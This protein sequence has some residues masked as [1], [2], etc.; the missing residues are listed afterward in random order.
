MQLALRSLLLF[1]AFSP[2]LRAQPVADVLTRQI[3]W[4]P[5][6][7]SSGNPDLP[8]NGDSRSIEAGAELVLGELEGPGIINH[9]WSTIST[10]DVF[11][12]RSLVL[13]IYYDGATRPSVQV[14]FGDFFGVGHGAAAD[15]QSAITAISSY[16]RARS[17]YWKMPFY[18]HAKVV[19]ANDGEHRINSFYY[20]LDW[21][22]HD[23][24]P[25][26]TVY[27][28]ARYGQEQATGPEDFVLLN[29]TGRGH[30]VGT[31]WSCQMAEKGWFGEGDDRFYI[32]GE[33]FPSLR[34]T[35]TEDYFGDAWG[36]RQF[37]TPYFG[38]SLWEGYMPGDRGTAYRW[39]LTDPIPF[40]ESLKVHMETRGSIYGNGMTFH[41]QF[42]PRQDF[43]SGG[44]FWYQWPKV[45]IQEDLP[46]A[47]ERIAPYQFLEMEDLEITAEPRIGM[48]KSKEAF[49]YLCRSPKAVV[50]IE[51]KV[52][53]DGT[54][55]INPIMN[56]GG[57]GGVYQPSINGED[58]GGPIDFSE[59]GGF[60]WIWTRLDLHE[61]EAQ[62][63]HTLTFTGQG[64]S[65]H[66]RTDMG[67]VFGLGLA[68]IAVL[69]VED[70]PGYHKTLEA[71]K[72]GTIKE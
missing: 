39:H 55:Q 15:Y 22:K 40:K 56:Y 50:K 54:Y 35:G 23:S 49:N 47:G 61:L 59:K 6:R 30:Y 70:L 68:R 19:V 38:V 37:A 53:E 64:K 46:S 44:A 67:D 45:E 52:P 2:S 26:D 10:D 69:R 60:D 3:D 63:T 58:V 48:M 31:V 13:R 62:K 28:H 5:R 4:E 41:G 25:E 24:L 7:T 20:Y 21:E 43:I 34:G 36:F 16:G 29:T 42:L 65:P 66:V 57:I 11:H 9:M 8:K 51:F 1:I 71:V 18:K 32:D 33:D 14:P 17:C 12:G 72:A 27:F